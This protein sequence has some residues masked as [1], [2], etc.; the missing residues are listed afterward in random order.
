MKPISLGAMLAIL[1]FASGAV[2]IEL[3]PVEGGGSAWDTPAPAAPGLCRAA[4]R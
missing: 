3:I 1:H 2:E 4:G